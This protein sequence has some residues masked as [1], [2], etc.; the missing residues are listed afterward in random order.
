MNVLMA[1]N[2][3]VE[4]S[5]LAS[6]RT[7]WSSEAFSIGQE[8]HFQECS[9]NL[10]NRSPAK[11]VVEANCI[12]HIRKEKSRSRYR[13]ADQEAAITNLQQK[14]SQGRYKECNSSTSCTRAL[15]G[16]VWN[17]LQNV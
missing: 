15:P 5:H 4:F 6:A 14:E 13:R 11:Y 16:N 10:E 17:L 1:E 3:L 8:L 2:L 12:I 9:G 7:F